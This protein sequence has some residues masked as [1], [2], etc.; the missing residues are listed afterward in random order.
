MIVIS[1]L[2]QLR[3]EVQYDHTTTPIKDLCVIEDGIVFSSIKC[4]LPLDGIRQQFNI[5]SS[6]H[7]T[8]FFREIWVK[9]MKK[10][11]ASV[12]RNE[13]AELTVEDI[14]TAIWDPAFRECNYLLE[15]LRDRSI[16]LIEVDCYF[17]TR[18]ERKLQLQRLCSGVCKCISPDKWS[19]FGW[20]DDAIIHMESYWSLLNLSKAA[21]VV[22]ELKARLDLSGD[23]EDIETLAIEVC[24]IVN[25]DTLW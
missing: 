12:K 8:P 7:S 9:H 25:E 21:R 3:A 23:F 20:I 11:A 22:M 15:S 24:K 6:V 17:K 16:K 19:D 14:K 13:R 1:G 2:D 5:M 4:A 10:A 18:E